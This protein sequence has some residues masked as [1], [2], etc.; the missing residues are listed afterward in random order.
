MDFVLVYWHWIVLGFAL[1]LLEI[2]LPTFTALWFGAAAV[3][4]GGLLWLMPNLPLPLQLLLWAALSA[5]LT[6]AWFR[7]LKPLSVDRTKAGMS[8]EAIL[9]EVGQVL[10]LPV[11][12]ERGVVRFPAPVLGDDEWLF[13]SQDVLQLGD[14]VRVV[15]VSGNALMVVK[16]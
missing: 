8:R 12:E 1:M 7:Y 5:A 3:L 15:D 13:I 6:W 16:H 2:F 10:R 11:G 4:V 14:R 9:G